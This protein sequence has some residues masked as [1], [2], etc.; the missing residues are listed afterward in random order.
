M[1]EPSR[2]KLALVLLLLLVMQFYVRPRMWDAD[3]AP[4]FVM[5]AL[6]VFAMRARPGAAAAA[7]FLTGLMMDSLGPGRFG[8]AALANTM[9]G[10]MASYGRAVFFADNLL[11]HA[12]FIGVG[13]WV[14]DVVVLLAS[15]AAG[16][17]LLWQLLVWSP[18]QGLTTAIAGMVLLVVFRDWLAIRLDA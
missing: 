17:S 15:G 7:G 9:V 12:G 5:L 18:L 13:V 6:M 10:Y 8:A 2:S 14:R 1:T 11:V 3:V 4:D 16:Q